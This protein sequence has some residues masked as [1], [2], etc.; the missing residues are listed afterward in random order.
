MNSFFVTLVVLLFA[1]LTC[2]NALFG[3]STGQSLGDGFGQIV[4]TD[5]ETFTVDNEDFSRGLGS[6]QFRVLDESEVSGRAISVA[7][8]QRGTN[9]TNITAFS[10]GFSN[11]LVIGVSQDNL[12]ISADGASLIDT[13]A[14]SNSAGLNGSAAVEAAVN[15]SGFIQFQNQAGGLTSSQFGDANYNYTSRF[16]VSGNDV[17]VA[18][19][20]N[21]QLVSNE[22]QTGSSLTLCVGNLAN[23][24]NFTPGI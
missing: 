5:A 3:N 14:T 22:N 12:G 8:A 6:A 2:C 18:D 16:N 11:S 17:I 7:S 4:F 15:G 1:A 20:V 21:V 23:C 19:L 10:D 9:P 24:S 13:F